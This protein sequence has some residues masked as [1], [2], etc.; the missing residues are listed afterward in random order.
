MI[1]LIPRCQSQTLLSW[2]SQP[3]GQHQDGYRTDK[4][5]R[6]LHRLLRQR[7][8]LLEKYL[9]EIRR[10]HIYEK[11]S[12]KC[13]N[14]NNHYSQVSPEIKPWIKIP[15]PEFQRY[16]LSIADQ[17]SVNLLNLVSDLRKNKFKIIKCYLPVLHV[18]WFHF[19]Q[20][21][22]WMPCCLSLTGCLQNI[23]LSAI[24]VFPFRRLR[25]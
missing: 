16:L 10:R 2:C 7:D 14:F 17:S 21:S 1:R 24:L 25:L 19:R 8:S 12:P 22:H 11:K 13:G 9:W 23:Q 20:P 5:K 18:R 4:T 15:W 3:L 6:Y